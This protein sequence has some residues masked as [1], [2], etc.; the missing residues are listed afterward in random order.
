MCMRC[1]NEILSHV[2]MHKLVFWI[3]E[4]CALDGGMLGSVL[5]CKNQLFHATG[6]V[7]NDVVGPPGNR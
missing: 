7:P 4:V 3:L 2:E 1:N 6:I 5:R